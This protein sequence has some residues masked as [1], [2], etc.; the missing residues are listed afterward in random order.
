[1]YYVELLTRREKIVYWSMVG[2]WF[3]VLCSF[4]LWWL[5][6]EHIV[7]VF[8]ILLTSYVL[9]W[10]TV[11]PA[12]Y[13]YFAGRMKKP[14]PRLPVPSGRVAMVVT[15]APSEPWSVVR[16]TLEAMLNQEFPYSYDV[17]LADEQPTLEV[18]QWCSLHEV[19]ISTRFGIKE[20]HSVTWPRRTK[21]K[22]GN[23][24]YFYDHYGHRYDY[25]AQ[26]D[27]DH[28]PTD[29]YLTEMIRPFG[30]PKVGYVAAPSV[31]DANIG[32]SW[33]VKAR[34]FIEATMHGSLQT[35]YN[36]GWAPMC[37]GS[38][39][40]VRVEALKA[41]GGYLGPELAEDHTTTLMMNSHGWSGAFAIDA[42]AHGDG[43]AS[44]ADSVTQ[45]FQWSR[46]LM[47]VLLNWTP[48]WW[49]GLTPQLKLE[50]AFAQL[51]YPMFAL[52][53]VI[54]YLM[55]PVALLTKTPWV[56]VDLAEFLVRFW[57][58]TLVTLLPVKF[59]RRLGHFRPGDAPVLS[60][61]M[62]LFQLVRWPWVVYACVQALAGWI[63][64]K[65]F[66]FRVTPKGV[67][68]AKP[69]PM[70]V[71]IPYV[72][73]IIVTAGAAL[74]VQD[75][76]NAKGYYYFTLLHA[77][78]YVIVL[79]AIIAL[80]LHENYK[81]HNFSVNAY[82]RPI[83]LT[84]VTALVVTAVFVYR[85][86]YALYAFS[87]PAHAQ[88]Q[89]EEPD[90]VKADEAQP[91]P[92]APPMRPQIVKPEVSI[93][94]SET[95]TWPVY[96][97]YGRMSIGAYDPNGLLSD[98]DMDIE[99]VY[100]TWRR[101][102]ADEF[103]AAIWD[104][105]MRGHVPFITLEPFPFEWGGMTTATLFTDILNGKYDGT[106]VN[107]CDVVQS[108]APSTVLIRWGHEPELVRRV[109]P[110][111]KWHKDNP[112][113]YVPAYRHF[114]KTCRK[115][116]A[117]N[118]MFVLGTTGGV[119]AENYYPG[120]EWVDFVGL[121]LLSDPVWSKL[122]NAPYPFASYFASRYTRLA[123]FG[124]PI[125]L[126][127]VGA[128]EDKLEWIIAARASWNSFPMLQG[129]VWFNDINPVSHDGTYFPDFQIG[130]EE[131]KLLR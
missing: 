8:G 4:W 10:G 43:A 116:G 110:W 22:E 42:E 92:P 40:A 57:I 88:E 62:Y 58:L 25:V 11:T 98:E 123:R 19:N 119:G 45:E 75:A 15:K 46:S 114:V 9:V 107:I 3:G 16:K 33:V 61:E 81:A 121:G 100:L 126:A 20:Y 83:A 65:E 103:S 86:P 131:W 78:T 21:S 72:I 32:E 128:S 130:P 85:A 23:L 27:A 79:L 35:G 89:E 56:S 80:H 99:H 1:M 102:N 6:S 111:S 125:I 63:L 66:G 122:W 52:Q 59:I 18:E 41:I 90:W 84:A 127:E 7:S 13:F 109:A 93:T 76:G 14:N 64:K 49:K 117:Y 31:C 60:W 101:E 37:I 74:I 105:L 44:F 97:P 77:M 95:I 118:S 30:D 28:V 47:H 106:I 54:S 67:N 115:A 39:Y 26:L 12:W 24:A 51:W 113:M 48:R 104:I 38:H 36:N 55:P 50:F 82:V 124:K 69:L 34:L 70:A 17:W 112:T 5:K 73:I 120:D 68:G 53:M 129:F 2:V 96:L 71:L 29:T 108:A 94:A 87:V 91:V